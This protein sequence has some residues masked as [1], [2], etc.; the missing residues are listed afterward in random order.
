MPPKAS[1]R[2]KKRPTPEEDIPCTDNETL[3]VEDSQESVFVQ[4]DSTVCKKGM[5]KFDPQTEQKLAEWYS[6]HPLFYD[7]GHKDYRD[8]HKKEHL[9]NEKAK[10][11]NLTGE[12]KK[13]S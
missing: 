12:Y 10:E 1:K 6:E 11:M 3:N 4:E 13:N 2:G 8:R 5:P 9:L 7:Q